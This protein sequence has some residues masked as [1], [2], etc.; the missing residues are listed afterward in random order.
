MPPASSHWLTVSCTTPRLSPSKANPT[1]SRK[2]ATAPNNAH[3]SA[4][5]PNHEHAA[6]PT[7]ATSASASAHCRNPAHL[8]TGGGTCGVRVD[9]Q[10]ARQDLC[11]LQPSTTG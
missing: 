5:A 4:A 2:L 7:T 9:R 6:G 1:A 10:S 11:S 8:D 3:A